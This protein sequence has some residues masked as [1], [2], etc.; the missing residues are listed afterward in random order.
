MHHYRKFEKMSIVIWLIFKNVLQ[1][2]VVKSQR[3]F[4]ETHGHG[5]YTVNFD[6]LL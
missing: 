1:K 2:Q 6:P 5:H 3:S 4:Y